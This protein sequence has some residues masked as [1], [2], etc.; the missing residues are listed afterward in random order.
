MVGCRYQRQRI[1]SFLTQIQQ[2]ELA[3][4]T[5][6]S[7][8][9]VVNFVH[10]NGGER[11]KPTGPEGRCKGSKLLT[12][13]LPHTEK[14]H[15]RCQYGSVEYSV[16]LSGELSKKFPSP[17]SDVLVPYHSGSPENMTTNGGCEQKVLNS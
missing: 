3:A 17:W 4:Y 7:A 2:C 11:A 12:T 10:E 5:K 6:D 1:G 9:E 8:Q 14:P 13:F 16:N 15:A